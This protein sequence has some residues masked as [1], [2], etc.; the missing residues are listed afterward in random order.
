[1]IARSDQGRLPV[2]RAE[3]DADALLGAVAHRFAARARAENRPVRAEDAGGLRVSADE[4]R[5]EQA[6]A[7]MV[8]NAL[9]YGRGTIRLSAESREGNVFLHVRDD[10]PGFPTEFLPNAFERFTRADE[11]RS[12]GGTGLGLAITA[13]IAT[14]HGGSAHAANVN[15]GGADVWLE[16]PD[17]F[18]SLTH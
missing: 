4:A 1:V 11:A 2:R 5:L 15:G 16:L 18:S 10:G 6:L 7:N 12:R 13:A 8:E 9:R 3:L 17:G 14:A